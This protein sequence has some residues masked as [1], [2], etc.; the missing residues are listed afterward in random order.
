MANI[1]FTKGLAKKWGDKVMCYSLHP[2]VIKSE[3]WRNM[4]SCLMCLFDCMHCMGAFELKTQGQGTATQV[5]AAVSDDVLKLRNGEYLA[6][7]AVSP[8]KADYFDDEEQG[9]MEYSEEV[10]GVKIDAI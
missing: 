7:C 10:T 1:Y 3:I 8:L 6:D 4:N 2:G 5:Y 9:L